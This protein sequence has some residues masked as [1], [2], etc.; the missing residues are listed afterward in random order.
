MIHII[1]AAVTVHGLVISLPKPNR[2]W[3]IL[4][5]MPEKFSK[6][7]KPSEQGFLTNEGTFV[8]REAGKIIARNA[9]QLLPTHSPNKELFSEDL[10]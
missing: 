4:H 9:N 7:V 10:W 1:S 8:G 3:N 5:K 2:H 6:L